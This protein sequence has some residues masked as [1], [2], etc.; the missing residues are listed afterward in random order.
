MNL[1][2]RKLS[3]KDINK[4]MEII[5]LCKQNLKKMGIDQWQKGYP[6]IMTIETDLKLDHAYVLEDNNVIIGYFVLQTTID[7][8]YN[9]IDGSWLSNS[10]YS[11]I[12]RI[13]INPT[14][15]NQGYGSFIF[16]EAEKLSL[17]LKRNFIRVDTGF[18]NKTM[19]HVLDKMG[20]FKC[21]IVQVSDGLR[22][23]YEKDISIT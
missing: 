11:A 2:I 10:E 4:V 17:D 6:N 20:Y 21:G 13:A 14:L 3:S 9:N 1:N 23:A 18:D 8:N 12:H 19:H 5:D 15:N 22:Y 7:E 16:K